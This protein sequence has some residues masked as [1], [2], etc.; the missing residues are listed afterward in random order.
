MEKIVMFTSCSVLVVFTWMMDEFSREQL[1][2]N[3]Y[4]RPEQ[5]Q[6]IKLS[7]LLVDVLEYSET[8]NYF[9][10]FCEGEICIKL[11]ADFFE[12]SFESYVHQSKQR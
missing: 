2:Y 8:L 4:K 12:F 7:G 9:E 6:R 11:A 1:V 5:S 10:S 3:E